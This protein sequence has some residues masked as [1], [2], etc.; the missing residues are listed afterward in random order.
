MCCTKKIQISYKFKIFPQ[1]IK[2]AFQENV[3][4][5]YATNI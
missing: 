1:M 3:P 4:I 2:Y 5:T